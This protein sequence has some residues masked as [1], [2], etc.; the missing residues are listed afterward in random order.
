N[1]I[2]IPKV[3]YHRQL[4]L[5]NNPVSN[6]GSIASQSRQRALNEYFQRMGV[7]AH[8]ALT[9]GVWRVKY[10]LPEPQ[11]LVSLIIPTRNGLALIRQCVE[12]ILT[13]TQYGAYE[14]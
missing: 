13:K 11:P 14:I 10:A 3:L 4:A 9:Q 1:I 2:H 7:L 8:T 6:P 12:S 5:R